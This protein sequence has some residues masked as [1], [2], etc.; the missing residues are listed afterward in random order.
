MSRQSTT[1]RLMILAVV[2]GGSVWI[3]TGTIA[4]QPQVERPLV[5]PESRKRETPSR[6]RYLTTAPFPPFVGKVT[7]VSADEEKNVSPGEFPTTEIATLPKIPMSLEDVRARAARCH[8]AVL[9]AA[10]QAEALRGAWIQAGLQANP[11]IGYSGEEINRD[12]AGKQGIT[13]DQP[14][15]TKA[16]RTARQDA[17]H[18]EYQ[19]ACRRYQVQRQKA[20]NDALLVAYRAAFTQ[21]KC[22]LME[23]LTRI[24]QESLRTG[25]ELLKAKEI[26]R[27]AFLDIKIQSERTLIARKD[28]E[29]AYQT[30]CRELAV[31][32]GIPGNE[33][34]EITDSVETL[35][36]AIFSE[37]MLYEIKAASPELRQAYDEVEAAKANVRKECAEAGIDYNTNVKL[38]YRPETALTEVSLGI[39][40]PLRIFDRNQGNIQRVRSE[41]AAAHR[42]AGRVELLIALRFEKLF[43]EYETA[44]NRVV[45]YKERILSEARESLDLALDSYRRGEYGSLELLEAQRTFSTVRIEYLD[46]LNA[47]MESQVLLQGALLSGGLEKPGT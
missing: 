40:V 10:G 1:I 12:D 36:P 9:Q 43:G 15:I 27:S 35:P 20:E 34:I 22:R 44:R 5:P 18:R 47:L 30:A 13:L 16:K 33:L 17:V 21:R 4:A 3:Q 38:A 41:L 19:A 14:V 24:S 25:S 11:S 28:A 23:E 2:C 46:N 7:T 42:N 32:L 45:S 6:Y 39:S 8:P 29:I 37:N 26:G 31:L